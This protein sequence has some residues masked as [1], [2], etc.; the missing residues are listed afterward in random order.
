MALKQLPWCP[1][2]Q[3]ADGYTLLRVSLHDGAFHA[4]SDRW[5]SVSFYYPKRH[6][7]QDPATQGYFWNIL[8]RAW[9]G[10]QGLSV[11]YN[12]HEARWEIHGSGATH[13]GLLGSGPT[14]GEALAA[15]LL[16]DLTPPRL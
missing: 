11:R 10:G 12:E 15:A 13:G 1:G 9:S 8:C 6:N 7:L 16:S 5:Q 3:D 2:M 4:I 14:Y